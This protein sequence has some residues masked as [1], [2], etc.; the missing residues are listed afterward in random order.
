[1]RQR[2]QPAHAAFRR[3]AGTLKL[4]GLVENLRLL[5]LLLAGPT[6]APVLAQK[7]GKPT[8]LVTRRLAVFVRAGLVETK[9]KDRY[10]LRGAK[11][12]RLVEFALA[13]L[14]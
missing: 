11:M 6:S 8:Y 7:T 1:M 4:L 10:Q 9:R 3:A 2:K 13:R 5:V 12:R 14:R